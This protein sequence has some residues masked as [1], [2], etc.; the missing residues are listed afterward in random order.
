MLKLNKKVE[1]ALCKRLLILSLFCKKMKTSKTVF[2]IL[3][4]YPIN[5]IKQ[6]VTKITFAKKSLE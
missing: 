3:V 4:T 6:F 5:C 2:I 1:F